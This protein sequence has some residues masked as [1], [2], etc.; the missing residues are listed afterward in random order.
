MI[1]KLCGPQFSYFL[2]FH[3]SAKNAMPVEHQKEGELEDEKAM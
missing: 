1:S 3:L 2:P